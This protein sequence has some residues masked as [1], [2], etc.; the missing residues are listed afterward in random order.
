MH[1]NWRGLAQLPINKQS[2][3]E[4]HVKPKTSVYIRVCMCVCV[5]VSLRGKI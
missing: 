5:C 4:D 3:K 1:G 2:P